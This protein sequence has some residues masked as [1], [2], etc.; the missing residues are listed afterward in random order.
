MT[1]KTTPDLINAMVRC[2]VRIPAHSTLCHRINCMVEHGAIFCDAAIVETLRA[3]LVA[4][5]DDTSSGYVGGEAM[6]DAAEIARA[7]GGISGAVSEVATMTRQCPGHDDKE[8][9]T[10]YAVQIFVGGL[11]IEKLRHSR[12]EIDAPWMHGS[13]LDIELSMM[14]QSLEYTVHSG[15]KRNYAESIIKALQ[16]N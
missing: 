2:L 9:C 3:C 8:K 1:I 11:E 12:R 4:C 16:G 15:I 5:L 10:D 13:T 7:L 14:D 6:D